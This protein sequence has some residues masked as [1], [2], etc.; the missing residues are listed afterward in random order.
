MLVQN[1]SNTNNS[2]NFQGRVVFLNEL[3][4]SHKK[5]VQKS[6]DKLNQLIAD[7]SYDLFIK[8][9]PKDFN[10]SII[11]QKG[12]DLNKSGKPQGHVLLGGQIDENI[13]EIYEVG[14]EHACSEYEK[15]LAS[16]PESFG[17]KCKKFFDKLGQKFLEIMQDED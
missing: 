13:P 3:S 8:E 15:K 7:K 6:M 11:A 16:M 17:Q 10:I 2:N 1:I 9:N 12:K 5:V 4:A 14:A